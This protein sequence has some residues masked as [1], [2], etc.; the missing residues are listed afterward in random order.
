MPYY[1]AGLGNSLCYEI[2]FN[3]H[4][5]VIRLTPSKPSGSQ[6][7]APDATY[8]ISNISL[9]YTLTFLHATE[10]CGKVNMRKKIQSGWESSLIADVQKTS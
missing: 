6:A 8:K 7:P 1:Q 5:S 2:A 9:E 3:D 4:K 10:I